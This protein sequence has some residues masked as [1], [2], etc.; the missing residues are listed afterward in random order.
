[1]AVHDLNTALAALAII[2]DQG[3][4]IDHTIHDGDTSLGAPLDLAH[5]YRFGEIAA[6]RRFR[7]SDTPLTGPTGPP[8]PVDYDAV[9]PMRDDPSTAD[10]PARNDVR[11]LSSEFDAA[12][13][14][15]LRV[16]DD[17]LNG[18]PDRLTDAVGS[19]WSIRW[20]A[21]ALMRV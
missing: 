10:L 17:A 2:I 4:G 18:K 12:Y 1:I 9:W 11:E 6:G 21:E 3:E 16:L 7:P 13:S 15:L 14:E 19:M 20:K 5:Y 8:L